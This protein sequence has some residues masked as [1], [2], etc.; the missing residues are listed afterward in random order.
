MKTRKDNQILNI[1]RY[2][3]L[4]IGEESSLRL[5]SNLLL[6]TGDNL[7]VNQLQEIG[8]QIG[9]YLEFKVVCDHLF[10]GRNIP[11][12]LMSKERLHSLKTLISAKENLI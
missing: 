12:S 5:I 1:N 6:Q 7:E 10:L 11:T 2:C 8:Y 3:D 9:R 4:S